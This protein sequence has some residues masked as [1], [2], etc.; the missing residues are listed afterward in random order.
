LIPPSW[1]VAQNF[2][3]L[4]SREIG[5]GKARF[6]TAFASRAFQQS[7]GKHETSVTVAPCDGSL[8]EDAS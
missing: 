2:A 1:S 5:G 3:L 6:E 8:P 4:H 7:C